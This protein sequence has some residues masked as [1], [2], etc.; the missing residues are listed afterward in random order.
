MCN[1]NNPN[2]D[3]RMAEGGLYRLNG[4]VQLLHLLMYKACYWSEMLLLVRH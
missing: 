1:T 3:Y 2:F 4:Y